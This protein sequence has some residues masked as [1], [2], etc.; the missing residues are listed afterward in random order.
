MSSDEENK[1]LKE[2][3]EKRKQELDAVGEKSRVPAQIVESIGMETRKPVIST[4]QVHQTERARSA[5]A[6]K[7]SRRKRYTRRRK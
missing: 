1:F 2:Q 4:Q 3:A 7:R 5:S 6:G